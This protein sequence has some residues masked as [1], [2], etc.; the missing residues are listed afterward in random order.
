MELF[1]S[2][3]AFDLGDAPEGG[4]GSTLLAGFERDPLVARYASWCREQA[5]HVAGIGFVEGAAGNRYTHD[6]NMNT[7][8]NTEVEA[9]AGV[10]GMAFVAALCEREPMALDEARAAK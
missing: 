2:G 1:L 6:I 8:F 9:A 4:T 3:G 5:V 7:N 10:D